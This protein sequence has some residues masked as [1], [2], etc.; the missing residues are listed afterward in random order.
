MLQ[1]GARA[2]TPVG[3]HT[4]TPRIVARDAEKL[5]AFLTQVFGAR[6]AYAGTTPTELVLGTSRILVSDA[7]FRDPMPAFLYVY[8]EDADVI[9]QR[10]VDLGARSIE[11]PFDTPYGDRRC[12]V[13]DQWRNLWQIATRLAG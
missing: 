11:A 5:V 8:V 3:W 12:T 6:G 13:E 9:Y 1:E 7:G 4:V 2:F 10:A